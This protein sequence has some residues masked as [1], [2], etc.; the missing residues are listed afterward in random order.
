MGQ[1]ETRVLAFLFTFVRERVPDFNDWHRVAVPSI[2][3]YP[4]S[5]FSSKKEVDTD[6]HR[7]DDKSKQ[8]ARQRSRNRATRSNVS[9]ADTRARCPM[10]FS[11][12]TLTYLTDPSLSDR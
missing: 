10:L 11:Y 1:W 5:S 2:Q 3:T 12:L 9:L 4:I 6:S 8:N 7:Y